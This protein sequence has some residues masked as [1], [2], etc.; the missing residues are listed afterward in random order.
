M[1]KFNKKNLNLELPDS[2]PT[3]RHPEPIQ[4]MSEPSSAKNPQKQTIQSPLKT[5]LF[6][7]PSFSDRIHR[8]SFE[9]DEMD[10]SIENVDFIDFEEF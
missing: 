4:E 6:H 8:L 9:D 7:S 10:P 2:P 3:N 5:S 1:K